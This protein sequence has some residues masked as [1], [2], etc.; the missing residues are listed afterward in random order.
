MWGTS[1][2]S[3]DLGS[4]MVRLIIADYLAILCEVKY[5][6]Y[7]ATGVDKLIHY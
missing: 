6:S 5:S 3:T 1:L 4:K 7:V 2:I